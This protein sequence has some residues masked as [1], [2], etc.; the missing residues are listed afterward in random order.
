MHTLKNLDTFAIMEIFE[1]L[2][3]LFDDL[4]EKNDRVFFE[5]IIHCINKK[6][7][8][9]TIP[10]KVHAINELNFLLSCSDTDI[11]R[12]TSVFRQ[13]DLP[14]HSLKPSTCD[15]FS[16]LRTFWVFVLRIFENDQKVKEIKEKFLIEKPNS[17]QKTLRSDYDNIFR[18]QH[19]E[20]IFSSFPLT[21]TT[22]DIHDM[23]PRLG[24]LGA[25]SFGE[26]ADLFGDTLADVIEDAPRRHDLIFNQQTISQLRV[27]LSY[28][29]E[30]LNR[31][32]KAILSINPTAEVEEPPNWGYYP[33]LRIFWSTVLDS[34]EKNSA[35]RSTDNT[36][37]DTT[38]SSLRHSPRE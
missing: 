33:T 26:D 15:Q 2:Y 31:V 24:D 36:E 1:H 29:D 32:S 21:F 3:H 37:R 28:T 6:R 34:F 19:N 18:H 27:L 7:N 30:E 17:E 11:E 23:F 5:N 22:Y 14:E 13:I 38:A 10:Y 4:I 35:I 8:E 12:A 25:G 20:M 9:Y 16:N